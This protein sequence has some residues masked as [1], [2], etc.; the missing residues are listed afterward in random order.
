LKTSGRREVSVV[1]GLIETIV[2]AFK[3]LAESISFAKR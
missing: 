1:E 2:K 3:K